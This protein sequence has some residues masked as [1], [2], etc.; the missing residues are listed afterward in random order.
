VVCPTG[1]IGPYDYRVSSMTESILSCARG[2]T[3]TYIEDAAYDFVDVRDVV[4]GLLGAWEKGRAGESYILSG[5]RIPSPEMH[6]M[7]QKITGKVF[8]ENVLP[9]KQA[10]LIAS[11]MAFSYRITGG[12]PRF[13]PYALEVLISNSNFSHAKA[14]RELGFRP[15][16]PEQ[17]FADTI[18][19][20]QEHPELKAKK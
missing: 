8:K 18:A 20:H 11:L 6:K 19:W 3:Q 7:I 1:V 4:A 9:L 15:R 10:R 16:P 13:T 17:S 2:E 5:T 14:S 12:T